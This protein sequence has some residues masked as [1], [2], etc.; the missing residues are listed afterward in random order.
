MCYIHNLGL[1]RS[2]VTLVSDL[3]RSKDTMVHNGCGFFLL[4]VGSF[5]LTVELLY[6]L[7]TIVAFLLAVGVFLL[8]I[9][10]F[11]YSW[12]FLLTVGEC[13]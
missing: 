1:W 3:L 2:I 10:L 5:L 4:R 6:L 13:I 11:T 7:L 9:Q 8:A 12:S